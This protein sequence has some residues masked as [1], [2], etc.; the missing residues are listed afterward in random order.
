MIE[1]IVQN[2][3]DAKNAEKLGVT[4]LELVS[5]I[6]LGGLTPTYGTV[7]SVLDSVQIPVQVMIRPHDYG[8]IYTSDDKEVMKKDISLLD[9]MG[10][11]RIVI[12]A[13][14]ENKTIDTVFLD[15]LFREFPRLNVT[16]HRAFDEV[17]DQTEAYHT[18]AAYQKNIQ[19]I[20]TSGGADDCAGGV[21]ALRALVQLQHK[22]QGPG[23]LPGSGL[24]VDNIRALHNVIQAD[25]YHFGSGVRR[26]RS[27]EER[28]DKDKV[29]GVRSVLG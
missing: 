8:F 18:L 21:D 13:L 28:V 14:N 12:G 23:I 6:Q 22:L 19:R 7:K 16:F 11:N 29:E 25:E 10:H 17:R 5:A 9:E 2:A 27:F 3:E 26:N 15:D 24:G 20:L 4:R 1:C